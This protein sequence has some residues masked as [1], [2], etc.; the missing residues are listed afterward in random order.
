MV[1]ASTTLGVNPY[2]VSAR[3]HTGLQ[4]RVLY[5]G[6]VHR[7]RGD[8]RSGSGRRGAGEGER[9]EGSG[10]RGAGGGEREEG[11]GSAA[12]IEKEREEAAKNTVIIKDSNWQS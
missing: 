6:K 4:T 8:G 1:L 11:S 3:V 9:E 7:T 2:H 5:V 12:N 10:R